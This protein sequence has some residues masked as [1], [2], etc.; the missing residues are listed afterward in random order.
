[1]ALEELSQDM[2][3]ALASFSSQRCVTKPAPGSYLEL[4][5]WR[6][7]LV[8]PKSRRMAGRGRFPCIRLAVVV[9]PE[10]PLLPGI[11]PLFLYLTCLSFGRRNKQVCQPEG[12]KGCSAFGDLL[13]HPGSHCIHLHSASLS[14][15]CFSTNKAWQGIFVQKREDERDLKCPI[16]TVL[17]HLSELPVNAQIQT[18][19]RGIQKQP[20]SSAPLYSCVYFNSEAKLISLTILHTCYDWQWHAPGFETFY[21]EFQPVAYSCGWHI[22]TSLNK[23]K[24]KYNRNARRPHKLMDIPII[25]LGLSL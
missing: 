1:M 21:A 17:S 10:T 19:S 15:A 13:R 9:L 24:E 25:N 22:N 7:P 18:L 6:M 8:Q 4:S 11:L 23:G 16:S 2:L 14:K 5:A 12:R 3:H 20:S